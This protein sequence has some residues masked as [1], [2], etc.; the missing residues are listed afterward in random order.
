MEEKK[1]DLSNIKEDLEIINKTQMKSILRNTELDS[2]EGKVDIKRSKTASCSDC[3][4]K[5]NFPDRVKKPLHIIIEVE[6][7]IYE[8]QPEDKKKVKTK[9]C[10][11]FIF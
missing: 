6:P 2:Y 10:A 8:D 9:G 4:K 1:A 5:V 7:F 11:C 3:I